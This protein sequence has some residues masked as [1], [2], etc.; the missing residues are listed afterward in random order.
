MAVFVCIP[1]CDAI[2]RSF[3]SAMGGAFTGVDNFSRV[4]EVDAFRL[5]AG[6]TARFTLVCI[7]ILLIVSLILALAV[8][9]AS[10]ES[11]ILKTSFLLPMALPAASMVLL[12]RFFFEQNGLASQVCEAFGFAP[13][14]F[15]NSG[16][17]FGVLAA[18]YLWKNC[19]Y[20]MVLW[21]GALSSI[22]RELYEAARV[23]GAGSW[24]CFWFVTLPGLGPHLFLIIVLSLLSSFKVFREAYLLAGDYPHESIYLLQ[25][26]FNNWFVTL[27]VDKLCA[28]AVLMAGVIF[29]VVLALYRL[30]GKDTA[31]A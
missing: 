16:R 2:R 8:R 9:K 31:D 19:G 22:P 27:D 13:A 21:L 29:A 28:A 30:L 4:V 11:G 24:S 10:G 1:F 14:D 7:P 20:T 23:D 5:A 3:F 18:A 12:W 25:H 26:L 15:L 17:A 6:N